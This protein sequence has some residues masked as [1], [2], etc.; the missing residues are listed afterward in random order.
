MEDRTTVVLVGLTVMLLLLVV[1]DRRSAT[2][3]ICL[4]EDE[5]HGGEVLLTSAT[6]AGTHPTLFIVDTA[7]AG[8][9]VL[10]TSFLQVQDAFRR[11][12]VRQRYHAFRRRHPAAGGEEAVD[13]LLRE[14]RC[15]SF[16]SGCTMR[17]MGIG[18]TSESQAD[19]LLC[20]PLRFAHEKVVRPASGVGADVFVT[21]PLPGSVHVL[22]CDW[23]LQRAPCMLSLASGRLRL[24]APAWATMGFH[25]QP[26]FMVGGAFAVLL[27]VGGVEMRIVVD[28]G[29]PAALT[30]SRSA[31]AR[32]PRAGS[33]SPQ[34]V[35][36]TGVNGETVCSEVILVDSVRFLTMTL[37]R[38]VEV[39]A[40]TGEVE[41]ADGYA[42][43]ALL[44]TVDLWLEPARIGMRRNGLRARGA[45]RKLDGPCP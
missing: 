2:L 32:V 19:L 7:Y 14:G 10:S 43:L 13:D 3:P 41:G 17:L 24:R 40:S 6:L 11:G 20:P 45:P 23:L 35:V 28:T 15:V 29:A 25:F 39:L 8:S 33:S 22:T 16:V 26:A 34:R 42:G 38:H 31:A 18:A 30:L 36:Q 37:A 1:V 27:E 4:T 44:R 9:P 5:Q 12:T 21:H